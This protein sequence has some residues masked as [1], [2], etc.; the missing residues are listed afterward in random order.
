MASIAARWSVLVPL[1]IDSR[2]LDQF[3]GMVV[4]EHEEESKALQD[5]KRRT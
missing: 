4:K 2:R 3:Y 5:I 1:D